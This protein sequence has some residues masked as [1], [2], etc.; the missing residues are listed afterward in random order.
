[1]MTMPSTASVSAKYA[2]V[3]RPP[4]AASSL[5]SFQPAISSSGTSTAVSATIASAMPSN[6]RM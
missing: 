2:C 6:P 5:T 1:M 4:H 3:E